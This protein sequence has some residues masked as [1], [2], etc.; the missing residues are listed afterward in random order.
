MSVEIYLQSINKFL[1]Y[2]NL[3]EI[4]NNYN[5]DIISL[6]MIDMNIIGISRIG[7]RFPNIIS[8]EIG[9]NKIKILDLTN[10]KNLES[11]YA[12]KNKI[13]EIIGLSSCLKLKTLELQCNKIQYLESSASLISLC[14][15][16]NKLKYLFNFP[17]LEIIDVSNN[18]NFE[19]IINCPK[20]KHIN[21]EMTLL[22]KND[23][24]DSIKFEK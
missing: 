22:K 24:Y 4:P 11:L 10:F 5:E 8:L 12:N 14:A 19:Q 13:S 21:A 20:L 15:P 6:S 17:N 3:K 23:F 2:S 1:H 18:F 7:K 9:C 16:G